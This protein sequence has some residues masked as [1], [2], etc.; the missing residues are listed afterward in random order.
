M[1][2]LKRGKAKFG[3]SSSQLFSSVIIILRNTVIF[4]RRSVLLERGKQSVAKGYIV[5]SWPTW[6]LNWG[7]FGLV[8]W[9]QRCASSFLQ[10]WN[11]SYS[12][13][14]SSWPLSTEWRAECDECISKDVS[15]FFPVHSLLKS[16]FNSIAIEK[17]KLKQMVSEQDFT[18]HNTQLTRL[19]QSLS[20]VCTTCAQTD[21]ENAHHKHLSS[22]FL[23]HLGSL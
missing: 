9:W 16:A 20:Q 3:N 14:I 11:L 15:S 5:S 13:E 1:W 6:D 10:P 4:L 7:F 12:L 21:F 17:E 2:V 18:G 8:S 22:T 23:G 19:R